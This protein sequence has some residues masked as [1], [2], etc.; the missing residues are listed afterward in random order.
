MI[1]RFAL[2]PPVVLV[3][4]DLRLRR[5]Q[6]EVRHVV[7]QCAHFFH[8][9]SCLLCYHEFHLQHNCKPALLASMLDLSLCPTSKPAAYYCSPTEHM[10][11]DHLNQNRHCRIS[12]RTRYQS[13]QTH[14]QH[15]ID[16]NEAH[17]PPRRHDGSLLQP[18][19]R[20]RQAIEIRQETQQKWRGRVSTLRRID[21]LV[22]RRG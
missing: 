3:S 9:C 11:V 10:S 21:D 6:V 16:Q 12:T 22:R 2:Q 18:R 15:T 13:P 14:V 19:A 20:R 7:H 1:D 4:F 17:P 8:R 5:S